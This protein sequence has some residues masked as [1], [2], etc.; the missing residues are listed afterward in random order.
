MRNCLSM[1][2]WD[3]L[4]ADGIVISAETEFQSMERLNTWN[5]AL[6]KRGLKI[7]VNT[8]EHLILDQTYIPQKTGKCPFACCFKKSAPIQYAAILVIIRRI[9]SGLRKMHKFNTK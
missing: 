2:P 6:Q 5:K 3:L 7:N 1:V 4:Y 9:I 8:T